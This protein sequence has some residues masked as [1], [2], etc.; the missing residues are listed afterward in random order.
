MKFSTFLTT[1]S[2]HLK[3]HDGTALT[4][5]LNFRGEEGADLLKDLGNVSVSGNPWHPSINSVVILIIDNQEIIYGSE[6]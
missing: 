5:M 2:K 1:I 3:S 6:I 4:K